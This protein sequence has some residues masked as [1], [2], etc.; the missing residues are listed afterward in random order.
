MAWA[1]NVSSRDSPAL[2]SLRVEGAVAPIVLTVRLV[3][4]GAGADR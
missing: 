2:S 1:T 4:R 3:S